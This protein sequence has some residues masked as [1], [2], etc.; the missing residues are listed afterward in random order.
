M[1]LRPNV[2]IGHGHTQFQELLSVPLIVA[3]PWLQQREI[4]SW[5]SL[6]DI[7]A[8]LLG[9]AANEPE[10]ALGQA[11]SLIGLLSGRTDKTR[12]VLSEETEFGLEV[13][14]LVDD[15]GLKFIAAIDPSEKHAVFDLVND[16]RETHNLASERP[17]V[18]REMEDVLMKRL[19]WA[20]ERK[21]NPGQTGSVSQEELNKIGYAG[22]APSSESK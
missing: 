11:Q 3:A 21:R 20:R 6:P 4:T 14:A 19:A 22:Q 18:V 2:G 8:T 13:K 1:K 9:Y 5:V 16:P 10:F 15:R 7:S 17:E 12:A